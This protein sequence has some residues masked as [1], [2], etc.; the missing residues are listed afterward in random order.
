MGDSLD[1]LDTPAVV[2]DLDRLER[3]LERWQR[4]CDEAGLVNRPHVKTHKTIEIARRQVELGARGVTCQKLG[5]A[6]VMADAGIEDIL[7]PYNLIGEAKLR[8]LGRLLERAHVAATTDDEALLPG[9]AQAAVAAKRELELLVE[10]DTGLERAGVQTPERAAALA[11]AS[12]PRKDCG[13]P[14][15]LPIPRS[16]ARSRSSRKPLGVRAPSVS[17]CHPFPRA[18]PL[19]CG[20]RPSSLRP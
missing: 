15:S 2:V 19:R 12:K 5:E 17:T 3:N 11:C 14:A 7:I 10:C 8:R 1:V 4:Y 9:L 13:S 20:L 16:R 18:E 6:E